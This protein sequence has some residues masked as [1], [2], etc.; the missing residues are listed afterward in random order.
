VGS[1]INKADCLAYR[2]AR[3]AQGRA[4]STIRT[5]LEYLRACINHRYGKGNNSVWLPPASKPRAHYLTKGELEVLL[6]VVESP[7]VRL[8]IVLA[9]TTGARMTALLE[10]KWDM[11]DFAHGTLDLNPAGRVITNKH[12]VV[13]PIN[14][15][16]RLELEIAYA[17]RLSPFVIEYGGRPIASIKKAIR[18]AAARANLQCS[19][20]VFRHSA[21]VWMAQANIPMQKIAQYLGHTT[22]RV[23]ERVY[24]RYSPTFQRDAAEALEF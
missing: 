9:I 23:T 20:H 17:G 21:G 13:V 1:T 11:V 16:A 12:R 5:E 24:A 6:D 3:Q 8:F 15:R 19:P 4:D 14:Q 22:T 10:L 18:A 2:A 7:H